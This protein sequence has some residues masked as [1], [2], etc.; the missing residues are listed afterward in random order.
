MQVTAMVLGRAA[1]QRDKVFIAA[2]NTVS[3]L[4]G[5]G[6]QHNL[7]VPACNGVHR[8]SCMVSPDTHALS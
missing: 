2:G 8:R 3:S 7:A 1:K 5:N 4:A 6:V